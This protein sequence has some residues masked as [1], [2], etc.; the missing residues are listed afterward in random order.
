MNIKKHGGD[1]EN[2]YFSYTQN[3]V[4]IANSAKIN[5]NS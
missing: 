5:K 4:N 3:V 2:C 1:Y